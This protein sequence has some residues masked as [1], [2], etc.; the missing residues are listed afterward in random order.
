VQTGERAPPLQG[1]SSR[2]VGVPE[3]ARDVPAQSIP[4]EEEEEPERLNDQESAGTIY[5]QDAGPV[6]EVPPPY[7][8]LDNSCQTSD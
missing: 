1:E 6:R 8:D 3:I 2:K 4:E 7:S 5:H